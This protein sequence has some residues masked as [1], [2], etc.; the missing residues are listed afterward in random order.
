MKVIES[1]L[2]RDEDNWLSNFGDNPLEYFAQYHV[3][4]AANHR[5]F[6]ARRLKEL[7]GEIEALR[8]LPDRFRVG[9]G[10]V[11]QKHERVE[12]IDEIAAKAKA[13][14]DIFGADRVLLVPDCGF[15]TFADN[16]VASAEIAEQKLAA[17]VAGSAVIRQMLRV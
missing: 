17:I 12:S 3:R 5:R 7:P 15:A 14:I 4:L 8:Q 9:V 2:N 6:V 13:A 1:G 10:V 16:P 11:N